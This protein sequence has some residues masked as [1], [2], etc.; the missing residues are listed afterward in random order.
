MFYYY[1]Q[2]YRQDWS[3]RTLLDFIS[4]A[5]QLGL[6][7]RERQETSGEGGNIFRV[8]GGSVAWKF[9]ELRAN[10]GLMNDGGGCATGGAESDTRIKLKGVQ[11]S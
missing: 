4:W 11:P 2:Q 5:L 10:A 7:L 1:H 3:A 9:K 6:R 8:R